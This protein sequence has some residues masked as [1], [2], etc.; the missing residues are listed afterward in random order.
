MVPLFPT[1]N[2]LVRD[3]GAVFQHAA[4][5]AREHGVLAVVAARGASRRIPNGAWVTVDGAAGTV[6]WEGG[7][8][9]G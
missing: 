4:T 8:P 5:A 6:T 9:P 3:G 7:A 2:A 1:R